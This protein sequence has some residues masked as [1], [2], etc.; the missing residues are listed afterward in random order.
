MRTGIK[1]FDGN[2]PVGEDLH[3]KL[4]TRSKTEN[5]GTRPAIICERTSVL[6]H[7]LRAFRHIFRGK[8][9]LVL[10]PV[11]VKECAADTLAVMPLF[12]SD[13]NSFIKKIEYRFATSANRITEAIR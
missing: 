10:I 4:L 13:I 7:D 9:H 5:P 6:L 2:L 8:Y 12:I 3:I 1:Y 11:K